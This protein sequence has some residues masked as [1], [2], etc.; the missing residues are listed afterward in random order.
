MASLGIRYPKAHSMGHVRSNTLGVNS[1]ANDTFGANLYLRLGSAMSVYVN[2][3]RYS[4][5][6]KVVFHLNAVL[7]DSTPPT[8]NAKLRIAVSSSTSGSITPV[9]RTIS[10]GAI[11]RT[12]GAS[13]IYPVPP[14]DPGNLFSKGSDTQALLGVATIGDPLSNL[15]ALEF[16]RFDPA[17]SD[18]FNAW[19]AL[20]EAG[21]D[22]YAQ[23]YFVLEADAAWTTGSADNTIVGWQSGVSIV[24]QPAAVNKTTTIIN[25]NCGFVSYGAENGTVGKCRAWPFHWDASDWDGV[26]GVHIWSILPNG[27]ANGNY[28]CDVHLQAM[29]QKGGASIVTQRYVESFSDTISTS[30]VD[31]VHR[32]ENVLANL[33]DGESYGVEW[34]KN[35]GLSV[36][37]PWAYIEIIQED[38][39]KTICPHI[40]PM[41][42]PIQA[43]EITG[44]EDWFYSKG[45]F[46]PTWYANFPDERIL[47]REIWGGIRHDLAADDGAYF[48]RHGTNLNA[49]YSTDG[50]AAEVSPV[51]NTEPRA[52]LGY[53]LTGGEGAADDGTITSNDPLNLVGPRYL[54]CRITLSQWITDQPGGIGLAYA[55][56]VPN[57][58]VPQL[59]PLFDVGEFDAEGCAATS[60]GLGE[61]PLLVIT[62]GSSIPQKFNPA[63]VGT[64]R[65]IED[66]GIPYPFEGEVP[67]ATVGNSAAT[68]PALGLDAAYYGYRYTFRNRCTGKESNPSDQI[69]VDTTGASPRA[70]VTLS[71]AG[72]RIPGD[73]QIDEI[74][75]YRTVSSLTELG[76]STVILAKVGC[77]DIDTTALFEDTVSD[78]ALDFLNDGISFLNAPMPCVTSVVEFRNRLFGFGDIP[79]LAPVGTVSV[80][81]GSDIVTGSDDVEWTRCFEGKFIQIQG[82]CRSYEI[83][84]VLP[85]VAGLSPPIQRLKLVDPYEGED[86]TDVSYTVCGRPN[87]IYVSE[88]L[89]PECWPEAGFIDVEPGDGDRII[90]GA[91]NFDRL[92]ICKRRK[93][94]VMSFREFPSLEVIVPSRVSSDIGCI[95]PRSFAQVAVGTV[96]LSDRGLALFDG[97]GVYHV[98]ESEQM[99]DIFVD[100]E[101]PNY[102]RRDANGRVIEAVGVFYPKREQY[103]LLLP[104]IE[105]DRGCNLM[106]VWD[107]H[108][109]NV[110]LLKFCQEFL[111]MVVGKDTDG[112]ERVYLGDSNGFVWI[113]DVGDTDGAGFPNATGTVRGTI[114]SVGTTED[115]VSFLTIDGGGLIQGGLPS[116][117][118]LSGLAGLT[119]SFDGGDLGLAGVCIY[120]RA[121]DAEDGDPW[122]VRTIFAATDNTIYV[123]VPWGAEAPLAGYEF[124]IGAIEFDCIFKP[125]NYGT[126]DLTKRNWRQVLVHESEDFASELKVELLP[127]FAMS[128]PEDET[129]IDPV[130][131][132]VGKGRVFRMDFEK[133]RQV[134]P[135][136]RDV[137]AYEG[138][139]FYN[140]A[141]EAPIRIINHSLMM[142]PRT[143][144]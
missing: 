128:D 132:D 117:A 60:A 99:N 94:Y 103:L 109:K 90:G 144:K 57:S 66:V 30:N 25:A 115:G 116:L 72:V 4:S 96:W 75:V 70:K 131:Q 64:G 8:L 37:Q 102:V 17:S 41:A 130:T 55:L 91:S 21:D 45:Y 74:C 123:T 29:T 28:D 126:D 13:S 105:T 101:N 23:F 53:D 5:V 125:R 129:V 20:A 135:V 59:G 87:R 93:T 119:P 84:R 69:T 80:V 107:V 39:N 9:S 63:A 89:E 14:T 113:F 106:L 61:P 43:S 18:F 139:R 97:R 110:T 44:V 19:D 47:K 22:D 98:P 56:D 81:N 35:T 104:T 118:D 40:G 48:L 108:L 85:P 79:T 142:T 62:N 78:D 46:D 136:G 2:P 77:F 124:M 122:T 65:E 114:A 16:D 31:A 36:S 95:A 49:N 68:S 15:W 120:V 6:Q 137:H 11:V 27:G 7:N 121:A 51:V 3:A 143:S 50:S 32:S 82:D 73:S 88:P 54:G 26:T 141:P 138:V 111:S 71:F 86:D 1:S 58:E 42:G 127:D 83:A 10:P 76:L 34:N 38:F 92:V 112:D 67:S 133:G 33:V 140:F 134:R 24:Q 12:R 100:P 52:T